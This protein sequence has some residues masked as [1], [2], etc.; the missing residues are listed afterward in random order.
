M[1][2]L[3]KGLI[4]PVPMYGGSYFFKSDG[5]RITWLAG[6]LSSW[7]RSSSFLSISAEPVQTGCSRL[8]CSCYAIDVV[9]D[10]SYLLLVQA[11]ECRTFGDNITDEFMIFFQTSL[12]PGS[13]GIAVKDTG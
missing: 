9:G 7:Q 4:L 1:L 5:L 6:I 3:Q 2:V 12:L 13:H 10:Q 8:N 11:C